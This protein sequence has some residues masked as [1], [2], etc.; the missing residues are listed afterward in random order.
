MNYSYEIIYDGRDPLHSRSEYSTG[1]PGEENELLLF[2]AG[3][4][5]VAAHGLPLSCSTWT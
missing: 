5:S 3:L 1:S 4:V 2:L